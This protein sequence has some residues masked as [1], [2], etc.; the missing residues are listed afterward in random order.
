MLRHRSEAVLRQSTSGG[1]FTAFSDHLLEGGGVIYGVVFDE[2]LQVI[3]TRAETTKERDL[4]RVSKYVQSDLG[5][6]YGQM[7]E[8]LAAGKTVL[9]TGTPCQT[10]GVYAAF[11]DSPHLDRLILCDLICHSIPSPRVWEDYKALLEQEA[12]GKIIQVQ[13]RNKVYPWSRANSNRGFFYQ[14]EGENSPREDDRFYLLFKEN[15]AVRP[16]CYHC[17]F[18]DEKRAADLTIADYWGIENFASA[19]YDPLGV[20]VV[21]VN[22]PK[23]QALWDKST[24][25]VLSE[26]RPA[27]ESTSQQKRLSEPGKEPLSRA[28]FWECYDAYGLDAAIQFVES[29]LT[30]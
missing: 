21:L 16:S 13:F 28:E 29:R 8:D 1:A 22:S 23:G 5:N 14:I 12:G 20:S 9:F 7:Q 18:T 27:L 2:A 15:S 24:D 3:H 6:T 30:K 19:L 25:L 10:A 11:Q 4:M 17:P 26:E